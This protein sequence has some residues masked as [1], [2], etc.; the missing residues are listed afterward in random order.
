MHFFI[1]GGNGRTG[2][3]VVQE[4]LRR[5]HT[6]TALVRDP[7]KVTESPGLTLVKG[8]PTSQADVDAAILQ[9]GHPDAVLVTMN[10]PRAADSPFAK[11]I[12]PP[13]LM[14]DS[15]ANCTRAMQANGIPKIVVMQAFGVGTSFKN[16]NFLMRLVISKSEMGKQFEDHNDVDRELR[17]VKGIDWV[18]VRPA[19]LKGEGPLPIKEIGD[20]GEDGCFMPQCSRES[21]ANF[22]CDAAESSKWNGRTPVICN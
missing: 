15:V 14:A 21:V 13:R 6:V 22:I 4:A 12:S 20:A 8:T 9:G 18:M 7:S 16:L 10:A 11:S 5:G 2:A 19:M 17:E 3:V 1:I